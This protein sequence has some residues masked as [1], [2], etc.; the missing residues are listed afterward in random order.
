MLL[1]ETYT[2]AQ[3]DFEVA[4]ESGLLLELGEL[5]TAFPSLRPFVL[6]GIAGWEGNCEFDRAESGLIL[7]GDSRFPICSL[8][9]GYDGES[10]ALRGS[11]YTRPPHSK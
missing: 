2:V 10:A 8:W 3:L 1:F 6:S 4:T 11:G 9:R 7:Q 5:R